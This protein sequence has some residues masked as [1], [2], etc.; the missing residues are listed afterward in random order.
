[1]V[2]VPA[3]EADLD[4]PLMPRPT[5]AYDLDQWTYGLEKREVE[6]VVAQAF[7]H[8]T[9][10]LPMVHGGRDFYRRFDSIAYRLLDGGPLFITRPEAM[11]RHVYG[12]AVVRQLQALVTN[13]NARGAYNLA[14]SEATTV[15]DLIGRVA[16]A[17]GVTPRVV[18][19]TEPELRAR[20]LDPLL[21]CPFNQRWMS[22]L[23][24]T[25]ARDQLGF[26]H[27]PMSEWVPAALQASMARW[28]DTPP[29][30]MAHRP[31]ELA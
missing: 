9:L 7:A 12:P 5:D 28:N 27:E 21:A 15:E 10:R 18:T 31:L 19:T 1:M 6:R 13:G 29:P 16:H 17:L 2:P 24:A 20:G 22:A 4:G 11:V 25:R 26:T 3:R 23:D 14:Q 30:S 8:T